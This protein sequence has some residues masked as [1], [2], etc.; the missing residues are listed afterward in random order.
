[1]NMQEEMREFNKQ[2]KEFLDRLR[3]ENRNKSL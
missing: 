3:A 2:N 1:M